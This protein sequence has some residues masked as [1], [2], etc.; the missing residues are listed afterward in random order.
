MLC[1]SIMLS[2]EHAQVW[3]GSISDVLRIESIQLIEDPASV[4]SLAFPGMHD[5]DLS[6]V[7]S[8]AVF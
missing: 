7:Q 6:S 1:S 4:V 2:K 5:S 3:C 8:K